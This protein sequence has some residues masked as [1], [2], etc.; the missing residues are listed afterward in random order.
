MGQMTSGIMFGV[1]V[2]DELADKL[3][4]DGD[5]LPFGKGFIEKWE[6]RRCSTLELETNHES[7]VWLMGFWIV[8]Y[9]GQP[10][11][12][13]EFKTCPIDDFR[14]TY[15]ERIA[16]V[17]RA[18]ILLSEWAKNQWGVELP[19]PQFWLTETEVA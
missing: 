14:T 19:M 16:Q 12:C 2:P 6:R 15:Q 1:P 17:W 8:T 10:E 9:R 5:E 18:W 4:G 3:Y 13:P 11:G 7:A